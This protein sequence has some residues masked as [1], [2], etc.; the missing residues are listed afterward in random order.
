MFFPNKKITPE[1]KGW[2]CQVAHPRTETSSKPHCQCLDRQTWHF[3][4]EMWPRTGWN[5]T[6]YFSACSRAPRKVSAADLLL[7]NEQNPCGCVTVMAL[8]GG[9]PV[10]RKPEYSTLPSL[11]YLLIYQ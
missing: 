2:S 9:S 5:H 10:K 4:K 7:W 6:G 3:N 11:I 1:K 8:Q